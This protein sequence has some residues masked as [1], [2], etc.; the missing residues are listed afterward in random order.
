MLNSNQIR[1]VGFNFG[2]WL[3]QSSL[4]ERYVSDFI[5]EEDFKTV[6]NWGFNSIRLPVDAKWL[7]E[8]EGRGHISNNRLNVL[9]KILNWAKKAGLL[10]I[11][12][13]HQVPWHSFSKPELENLWKSEEDLTSFCITWAELTQALKEFDGLL[14]FDT[15]NEPTAKNVLDWNKVAKR[16]YEAIRKEDSE[17]M[18]ILESTYWASSEKLK[19]LV[20]GVR[21]T[22]IVYSFHFYSPM[23]LTHQ[24][25]PWWSGAKSY[26]ETVAYP[27]FIPRVKEYLERD[28]TEETRYFI[29]KEGRQNWDREA[30]RKLLLPV[31]NLSHEGNRIYC[32]EFGVYEKAPREARLNWVLDMVELMKEMNLGWSY[33]N[34][35]WLDFGLWPKLADGTSGPLDEEMVRI[36]RKGI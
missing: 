17:R 8:N 15:L 29:E 16:V 11:L 36:L 12:D 22:N 3:S 19:D 34:Y 18:V 9:R 21:G 30:L 33:W 31:E 24:M 2:G 35:K 23:L 32:G 14:W 7:F 10:T 6:A 25:A 20:S 26:R 4:E 5:R 1:P 27:G 13:L 28:I